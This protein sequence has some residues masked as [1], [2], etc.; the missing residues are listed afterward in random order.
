MIAS[1]KDNTLI[2]LVAANSVAVAAAHAKGNEMSLEGAV[3]GVSVPLHPGAAK[4]FE[5]QGLSAE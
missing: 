5:E 1:S 3:Q 4:Y 2:S